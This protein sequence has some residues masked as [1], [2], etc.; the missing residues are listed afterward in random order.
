MQEY[1]ETKQYIEEAE[2][3]HNSAKILLEEMRSLEP[4][5]PQFKTKMQQLKEAVMHHVEEEESE[6]FNAI[7]ECMEDKELQELGKEFQEVKTRLE[8]DIEAKI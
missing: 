2:E 7:R 4:T 8:P 6:I 5:D 1:E 3:E